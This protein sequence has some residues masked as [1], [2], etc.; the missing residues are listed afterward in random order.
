MSDCCGCNDVVQ[1]EGSPEIVGELEF[2]TVVYKEVE[3]DRPQTLTVR[4]MDRYEF[5]SLDFHDPNTLY[6]IRG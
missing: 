4:E 2:G 1:L 5:D 6:M 3:V